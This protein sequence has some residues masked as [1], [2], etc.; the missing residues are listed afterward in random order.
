MILMAIPNIGELEGEYLAECVRT[1]FV[2]TVGPFVSRFETEV[3]EIHGSEMGVATSAGTTSLH[4]GLVVLGVKPGDLV[5]CPSF[6]FIATANA[7]R[8]QFAD[9]WL[10]E[11]DPETWTIDPDK[12]EE[13]L[14]RETSRKDGELIHTKSGKRV[15]AIVP[16]YTLGNLAD[17]DRIND[18]AKKF[19]LPILADAAAA[20]GVKYRGRNLADVADLTSF[21]FNG[22]KTITSGGG[23]ML[24]GRNLEALKR[25][26]HLST[27]ARTS[28]N[29]DYDEVGFN[30]RMTNIQAAVGCAQ[31]QSL[32]NFLDRKRQVRRVYN[33]A[34]S[35]I[36]G[37]SLFPSQDIDNSACWFS[38]LILDQSIT[39]SVNDVC[40]R[41]SERK[42]QSRSFW[43]PVHLQPPYK[44]SV[45]EDMTIT[46]SIWDN[47]ITLPCSTNITDE[48]LD[49]VVAAVSS[50]LTSG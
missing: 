38:G 2:S 10:M 36:R 22:N 6:T 5:I 26:K 46:N 14:K 40:S 44:N 39:P 17:M 30:Y 1:N 12:M 49:T 13:A 41:L 35:G 8:H 43:K 47:V 9:P 21:S 28:P 32:N 20:I 4:V 37:V 3:A 50:I 27:T 25:A 48:E 18:I 16:V 19:K 33:K 31:L 45:C 15:A 29:Y 34:F 42:I 11:V 24:I 7:I 23:G